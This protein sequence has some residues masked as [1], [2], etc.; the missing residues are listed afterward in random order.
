M[1]C[2][3]YIRLRLQYEAALRDWGH[4]LLSP[5]TVPTGATARLAA[6]LKEKAFEERNT[7]YDRLWLHKKNCPVCKSKLKGIH[8][9]R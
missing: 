5:V 6:D 3:E 9:S 4:V 8:S 1:A 7:A 2:H